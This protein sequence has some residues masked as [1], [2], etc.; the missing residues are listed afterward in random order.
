MGADTVTASQPPQPESVAGPLTEYLRTAYGKTVR[1]EGLKRLKGGYSREIW[2]FDAVAG[3]EVQ[4]LI[5]CKDSAGGAV[6][7]GDESLS[8]MEEA[9][10]LRKLSDAGILVPAVPCFGDETVGLGADFL[11]M[12]RVAGDTDVAPLIRDQHFIDKATELTE[13][14]ASIL[15]AV[16]KCP[17]PEEVFGP[18]SVAGGGL[19]EQ[20]L[21]RWQR[22]CTGNPD[23]LTPVLEKAIAWLE[24]N[25]PSDPESSV[26]THGDFRVGNLVYGR[27]GVRSVLDWEMAHVGDPLE[28]VAWAQLVIWTGRVGGLVDS[29]T[30]IASYSEAAKCEI[31]I[32][33]LAFWDILSMVKMSSLAYRAS[34][35]A[36]SAAEKRFLDHLVRM[37]GE[38]LGKRL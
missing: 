8:R 34:L 27:E 17:V 36:S 37:L 9:R 18:R 19:V 1:V 28:D 24:R 10:L 6:E 25:V 20:E 5:L 12:E 23:S 16:H 30:W 33:R 14:I 7:R 35:H 29:D 38:E 32:A 2:S 15:A 11:I 22:A 3:A 13:Q 31:D 26:I 21:G 4:E